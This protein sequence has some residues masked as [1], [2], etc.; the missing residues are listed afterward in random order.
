MKKYIVGG[1]IRDSLLHIPMQERD[2]VVVGATPQEMINYGYKKV[3]KDFPVFLHPNSREEYALARTERKSGNG[4]TGFT[5]Y[6]SPDITLEEDLHRRDLTINAI[7]CD[8][9]GNFIDPYKGQEDIKKRLLRH[10]SE[11]FI[12]DPLRVLRVARFAAKFFHLKFSIVPET[13]S[14]MKKMIN[15]LTVI[16]PE[17]IWKETERALITNNPQVYFKVLRECGALKILFP[18]IDS[19]FYIPTTINKR[20]IKIDSGIHTLLTLTTA[21]RLSDDIAVRFSALCHDLGKVFIYKKLFP[22]YYAHG[23]L[24]LKLV[25]KLCNRIKVPNYIC[26]LAKIVTKYHYLIHNAEKIS[27]NKLIKLLNVIDVWRKPERLEQVIIASQADA[28]AC[29]N[30]NYSYF[31]GNFLREAYRIISLI[32]T[33]KIIE[34]GFKGINICKELYNRRKFLLKKWKKFY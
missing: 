5:C 16:S 14:L 23:T 15:E 11:A 17:R 1:A 33:K 2:W 22:R 4:Y 12:E 32:N 28:N 34:D 6:A 19:L 18:E 25:E 31:Q 8:K 24:G 20:H 3:G 30:F 7:A 26:E 27:T 10:V 21:A 9:N 13:M 29:M